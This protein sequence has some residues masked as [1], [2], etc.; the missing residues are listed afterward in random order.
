MDIKREGVARKKRIRFIIYGILILGAVAAAGWKV[1]KLEPAAPT[2]E[3]ATVW[4]D[5]VKRGPIV[6]ERKGLGKLAPEEI[7]VIP[8]LQDGQVIKVPVK[9]GQKVKPDTILMVLTNPDM[10]LAANDLEWQMKQAVATYADLKVKLQSQKFDQQ[11]AVSSAQN[12]LKQASL[13][14]D[15]DEQLFKF[16]IQ[17]ELNV[18]LTQ[19]NW[20]QASSKF[21]T[22]KEKLD[23]MKDSIDAQ[24]ESQQVQIDK[25]KATWERKK[26]Q[27]GDLVI[28]AGT[29]GVV[30]E[31]TMQVGTRVTAGTVVAKV[32]QATL[33][34]ELQ[35]AE[36]QAKDILLGQKASIDTR[37]GIIPGHVVRIDPNVINGTRTV[38]CKLD[39]P[40]PSG[41]VPDLSVDGT[42]EIQRLA[43]VVYIGRPVFGQPDSS[44]SL[45]KLEP[46]G[47]GASRVTVKLGRSSV[48]TIEVVDGLKVGDQVILSDMSAQDQNPRIRL[49]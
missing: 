32:A 33:Q 28:R 9:S 27:L 11:A 47:K 10:E 6:I 20:E 44:V 21:Q 16:Q 12:A 22:E 46:D 18:K 38:D 1:S 24:L 3:R 45:F 49:D 48:N 25:L 4:I 31:L 8:S 7:I 36:T 26:Q 13:N 15:K 41:A 29:D 35:I 39:G 5:S 43:D 34:A 30:Q 14:K 37:N 19:A 2:V 17:N 40:L 23:I 42:V